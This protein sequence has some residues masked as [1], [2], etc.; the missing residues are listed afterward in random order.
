[1]RDCLNA[2]TNDEIAELLLL[3]STTDFLMIPV[4]PTHGT[5]GVYG[6]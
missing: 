2:I 4:C 3:K 6:D 5:N 1:M